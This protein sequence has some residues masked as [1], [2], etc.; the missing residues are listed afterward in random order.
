MLVGRGPRATASS[1]LNARRAPYSFGYALSTGGSALAI[2]RGAS[3]PVAVGAVGLQVPPPP[4]PQ[5]L[6]AAAALRIL[7]LNAFSPLRDPP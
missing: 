4:L 1:L 3:K 6:L 5:P 2:A 7:A